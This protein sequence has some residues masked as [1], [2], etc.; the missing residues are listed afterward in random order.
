MRRLDLQLNLSSKSRRRSRL[1][2][3]ARARHAAVWLVAAAVLVM[4]YARK[5]PPDA[6]IAEGGGTVLAG[7]QPATGDASG[8]GSTAAATAPV[9]RAA[10]LPPATPRPGSG[11]TA[12][13]GAPVE[14]ATTLPPT[15][16]RPGPG[17]TAVVT[18]PVAPLPPAAP[19]SDTAPRTVALVPALTAV[20]PAL[21]FLDS[22]ESKASSTRTES[23][24][25]GN[26]QSK[27][28]IQS[29]AT[30]ETVVRRERPKSVSINNG[31]APVTIGSATLIGNE[32]G[33]FAIAGDSC[34]GKMLE[35]GGA[36]RITIS[37]N[38]EK[39]GDY[40]AQLSI[41]SAAGALVVPV[42]G[43]FKVPR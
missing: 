13:V 7:N 34:S 42:T 21:T 12:V 31:A 27:E 38:P 6:G 36:C 35:P 33:V 29:T 4:A 9:E 40:S 2:H 37:F 3:P 32:S 18:A 17:S 30:S 41:M 15:A 10:A 25:R 1:P 11:T 5:Q 16:G 43:S 22:E 39:V 14:R 19:R 26:G 24:R 20:P 23:A 8:P 28:R